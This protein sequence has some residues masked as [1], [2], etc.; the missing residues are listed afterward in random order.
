MIYLQQLPK[1]PIET[2]SVTAIIETAICVGSGGS[3]GSLA[4]QPIV[5]NAEGKLYIPA[6]QL[7]GKIRHECEKLARGLGWNIC[8][9]PDPNLMCSHGEDN[10]HCLI[11]QLFGNP[12]RQSQ[13]L[14]DDLI[15][16]TDL[17]WT[18]VIR[19]GVT[20]NRR[21]RTSED[22]KLFFIETSP[23]NA[24]LEFIGEISFLQNCPEVGKIL[25]MAALKQITAL[26][27]SKS[28]GLGWLRWKLGN[29]AFSDD[30]WNKLIPTEEKP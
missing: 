4:D 5:R 10:D 2:L 22:Q 30:V 17:E 24:E 13:I 23:M 1:I 25:V 7:K 28:T 9:P 21:R 6:S 19:P 26:G 12:T 15:C 20:I 11:C 18:E 3:S 16:K 8:Y 29:I 14:C 27:G